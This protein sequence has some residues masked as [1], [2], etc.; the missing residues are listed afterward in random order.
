MLQGKSD[1]EKAKI[2]IRML[3]R[4][5]EIRQPAEYMVGEVIKYV[6]HGR[7]GVGPEKKERSTKGE[8]TGM[9][10]YDGTP[11]SAANLLSDGICGYSVARNL[12]WLALT[13]PNKFNF[14]R[15]SGMRRW[16]GKRTDEYP[17]VK[18]WLFDCAE[19]LYGAFD[20]SNFYDAV[21]EFIRDG[22]TIGTAHMSIEED[23]GRERIVYRVPHF[24]ECYIAENVDGMV[25]TNYRDYPLTLQQLVD[26]FGLEK[27]RAVV[28]D[29]DKKYERDPYSEEQIV[30]A[31][32]PR[33]HYDPEIL[34]GTNKPIASLWILKNNT[35]L[36]A[37]EGFEELS[38]ITW[39]WRKNNDE[40][41]GRSPAWDAYVEIMTG[42]QQGKTNLNAGQQM[43]DPTLIAPADLRGKI[44]SPLR[45][46]GR[47][48]LEAM[49]MAKGMEPRPVVTNIQLPFGLEMQDRT[50]AKI[51]EHFHVDFFLMLWQAAANKVELTATQVIE[52]AGEKAAILG[53]RMGRLESEAWNPI[54]DRTFNL[55]WR[56]G[57]VPQPPAILMEVMGAR[58]EVDYL[59][60]LAQAQ[61]RLF[62]S[63]GIRLGIERLAEA[64]MIWPEVKDKVNPDEVANLILESSNFPDKAIRSDDEVQQLR[65][66]KAQELQKMQMMAQMQGAAKAGKDASTA[67]EPGSPMEKLMGSGGEA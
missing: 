19:V 29:F 36:I 26:K 20:R 22:A 9:D 54:I 58:I 33:K 6:H 50:D 3:G 41:Y 16:A 45:P 63:Q 42:Q 35:K 46:G 2:V 44:P 27:L 38:T 21:P 17:E 30:N 51:K 53:I 4:L 37:E 10:V 24:R 66:I 47:L 64:A 48:W 5:A 60:P 1:D 14:P 61:K 23:I 12:R 59:G 49:S 40:W 13:M 39:R 52:M 32:F 55:E 25:D 65:A 31:R 34:D 7:R 56:A 18:R 28:T 62:M 57:R 8:K 43:V 11:L 15:T 67:P